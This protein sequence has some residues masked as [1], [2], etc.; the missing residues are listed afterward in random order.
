MG[1]VADNCARD[2]HKANADIAKLLAE[3]EGL[4][5]KMTAEVSKLRTEFTSSLTKVAEDVQSLGGMSG[6]EIGLFRDLLLR[7]GRRIEG[8]EVAVRHCDDRL[9]LW[10]TNDYYEKVA[11][12]LIA[13]S[14][15][16]FNTAQQVQYLTQQDELQRTQLQKLAGQIQAVHSQLQ[17]HLQSPGAPSGTFTP[18]TARNPF[19]V[20]GAIANGASGNMES[21][22]CAND[23]FLTELKQLKQNFEDLKEKFRKLEESSDMFSQENLKETLQD[24]KHEVNKVVRENANKMSQVS[25]WSEDVKQNLR[26]LWEELFRMGVPLDPEMRASFGPANAVDLNELTENG[27]DHMTEDGDIEQVEMEEEEEE[28]EEE[29]EEMSQREGLEEEVE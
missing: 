29:D 3:L 15:S 24:M 25:D 18:G 28:E 26:C 1:D 7:E 5:S 23:P 16:W 9:S 4:T 2:V 27:Y 21:R 22:N 8:L 19:A 10:S 6:R 14:P 12:L 20:N 13:R 17:N 11:N